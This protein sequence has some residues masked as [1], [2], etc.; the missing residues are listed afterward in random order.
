MKKLKSLKGPFFIDFILLSNHFS[1]M[2]LYPLP[3]M[4]LCYIIQKTLTGIQQP[5]PQLGPQII[6]ETSQD[7][8]SDTDWLMLWYEFIHYELPW[9]VMGLMVFLKTFLIKLALF[10]LSNWDIYSDA[11]LGGH[12]VL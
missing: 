2:V 5:Q 12:H 6:F 10:L 4:I 11:Q 7:D 1:N 3:L 8:I 9:K